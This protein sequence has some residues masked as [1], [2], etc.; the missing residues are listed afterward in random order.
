[1]RSDLRDITLVVDRSGSMQEIRSDAEGGVRAF[2]ENQAKEP[3]EALLTLV[4]FNTEYE[5]LCKG[6]LIN[7]APEFKLM[8]RG[9]TALLDAMVQAKPFRRRKI[10]RLKSSAN[11]LALPVVDR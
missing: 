3:G 5:F 8:P 7:Q 9:G 1:M 10:R 6:V 2:I 11:P 4:Q